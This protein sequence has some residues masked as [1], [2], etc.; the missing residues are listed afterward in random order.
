MSEVKP[1][2]TSWRRF[3]QRDPAFG[4]LLIAP[5]AIWMLATLVYPLF[6]AVHLSFLD[7][8]FIG[9]EG[10]FI[11]LSNYIEVIRSPEFGATLLRTVVWTGLNVIFQTA[12]AFASALILDMEFKGRNF[13][14][15]WVLLPWI[16]PVIVLAAVWRWVLDPSLGVANYLLVASGLAQSGIPFL[17]SSEL[18]MIS[19]ILV[20]SW[21]WFPFYAVIILAGLQTIPGHLYE[22]AKIDGANVLQEFRHITI[23]TIA[24]VLTTV[25]LLSS[26]WAANVFDMLYLLTQGGPGFSTETLP[27]MIHRMGFQQY[28]LSQGATV[29][30]LMFLALLVYGIVY[31]KTIGAK[32]EEDR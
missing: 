23:P 4:Y 20:N 18:A 19:A 27:I 32:Q 3:L 31:M 11:G 29:A 5:I 9:E 2:K 25:I 26:L 1:R 14:R 21:R 7:V 24:P 12:I 30:V 17:G 10:S 16:V 6:R 28:R 8:E 22:S 15:V 13:M